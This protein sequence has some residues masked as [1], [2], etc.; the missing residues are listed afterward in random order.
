M[1]TFFTADSHVGHAGMLS[2]RMGRPRPFR[3]VEEMDEHLVSAWNNRVKRN[4]TVWHLGDF[5][6][7]ASRAHARAIFDRLNGRKLL[8]RGNHDARSEAL[9]W[10][11][12]VRDVARITVQDAGMPKAVDLWLSHYAHI[13]WEGRHR[14]RIHLFGHSHG[15]IPPTAQ[16]C[17]VGVDCWV[18]RPVTIPEILELLADVA[19]RE[20]GAAAVVQ[21]AEAA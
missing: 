9:P 17:D 8:I 16:S 1:T 11:E 4:D 18:F 15:A 12:P 13:T 20:A 7:G 10:A 6:Y 14:G 2:D 19:A 3:T 21:M 5:S